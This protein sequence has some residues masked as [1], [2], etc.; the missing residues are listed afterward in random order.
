MVLSCAATGEQGAIGAE[1]DTVNSICMT[2]KGA[3]LTTGGEF[4]ELNGVVIAATGEQGTIGA[5]GDAANIG[6]M[7]RESE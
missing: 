5:E 3:E 7:T 1:G 6:G 2:G 4:P